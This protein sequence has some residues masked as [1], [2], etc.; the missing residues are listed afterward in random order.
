M[1][2]NLANRNVAVIQA[3]FGSI[4]YAQIYDLSQHTLLW[5]SPMIARQECMYNFISTENFVCP[6]ASFALAVDG[7]DD[8]GHPYRRVQIT[9]CKGMQ[10]K[11]FIA[12][13][14]YQEIISDNTTSLALE[15]NPISFS[16]AM[17]KFEKKDKL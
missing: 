12:I 8:N 9:H 14:T 15:E 11:F 4:K 6:T 2:I 5:A 10:R 1:T 13:Y 17:A 16:Y 7:V 3:N